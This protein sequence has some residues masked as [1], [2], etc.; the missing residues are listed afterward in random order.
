MNVEVVG[1]RI[2]IKGNIKSFNDSQTIKS[3][4]ENL[5]KYEEIILDLKDSISITSALIGYLTKLSNEKNIVL[6]VKDNNLYDLLDDLGL[7]QKLN[8]IK[9]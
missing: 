5:T 3:V 8:V 6:R 7:I 9:V 2:I 1:N 4:I